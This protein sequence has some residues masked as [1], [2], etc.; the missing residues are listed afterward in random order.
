M[1]S[2]NVLPKHGQVFVQDSFY[3]SSESTEFLNCLFKNLMWT[4][5]SIQIFGRSVKEPRLSAWYGD[6]EAVYTYS[7]QTMAPLQWTAELLQIKHKV[8][9]ELKTTFNSVLANYYRDGQDYMGAHSDD[10][11]ELGVEPIIASLSF[12]S[13]RDFVFSLKKNTQ[14]K[15][16]IPLQSGS[17]LVMSGETQ[18]YW[19]HALPKRLKVEA[20]R[21]NL[22]FRKILC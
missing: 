19:K 5:R 12:G 8:E 21:L 4:Q 18:K 15:V 1:D 11:K 7:G 22:T 3:S 13:T 14:C 2:K 10:E 17:L 9:A 6:P 16:K 20:P